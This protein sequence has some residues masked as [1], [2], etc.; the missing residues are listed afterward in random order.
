MVLN[1]LGKCCK[2]VLYPKPTL[3][4]AKR[5]FLSRQ[6]DVSVDKMF[7]VYICKKPGIIVRVQKSPEM[8]KE[9]HGLDVLAKLGSHMYQWEILSKQNKKASKQKKQTVWIDSE[10]W[11][12]MLIFCLN[13]Q[14]TP[15]IQTFIYTL[16]HITL[17]ELFP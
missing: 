15:Y 17:Y 7:V 13:T 8:G 6:G 5:Y 9:D 4:I 16:S 1:L 3:C 14:V 11:H 12:L 2:S 10:D